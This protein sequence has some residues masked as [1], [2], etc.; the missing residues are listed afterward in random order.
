MYDQTHIPPKHQQLQ[1][2]VQ[3]EFNHLIRKQQEHWSKTVTYG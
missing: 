1:A 2:E 3:K